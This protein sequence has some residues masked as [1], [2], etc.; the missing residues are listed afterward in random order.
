MQRLA[1]FGG[2]FNPVHW[3]HLLM[4]E[5]AIEQF[6]L[7]QVIW[8]PTDRP[9]HRSQQ[10]VLDLPQRVEMVAQAIADHPAFSIHT[11]PSSQLSSYAIDTLMQLQTCYPLS[12]W[13]WIIGLDAFRSLPRWYR[14]QEWLGQCEWLV[15]PRIVPQKQLDTATSTV[16]P[17]ESLDVQTQCQ[18]VVQQLALQSI[19]LR[20]QILSMPL[21]DISS[22]LIRAYCSSQRSIRYLVP[23]AVRA[24]ILEKKLYIH[25][26]SLANLSTNAPNERS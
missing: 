26:A 13:Y 12:Q 10:D 6:A 23:E 8:V 7:D 14:R 21:V 5:T 20:W 2:T 15:A 17:S 16:I 1:I 18:Q 25:S 11:V 22:S 24:Y 9:S 3:G 19:A 4:A